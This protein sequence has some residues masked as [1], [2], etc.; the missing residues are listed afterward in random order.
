MVIENFLEIIIPYI[1]SSLDFIG[2]IIIVI[3]AL[4]GAFKLV[5]NKFDYTNNDDIAIDLVKAMVLS[6]E[7]KLAAEIA[8]TVLIKTIDEFVVLASVA[9]LRVVLS[10]VLHWE[11]RTGAKTT[12][13]TKLKK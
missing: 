7:F 3:S 12:E 1:S 10:F 2:I 6:L 11:L 4:R 9:I 13:N 5:A 8:K